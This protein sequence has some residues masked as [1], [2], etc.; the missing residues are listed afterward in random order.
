MEQIDTERVEKGSYR[1][2]HGGHASAG[3]WDGRALEAGEQVLVG[4]QV[5]QRVL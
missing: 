3:A 2:A 4:V 1:A 5:A